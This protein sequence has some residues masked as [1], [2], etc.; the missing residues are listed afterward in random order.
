MLSYFNVAEMAI[1]IVYFE[2]KAD[3]NSLFFPLSS[4][5]YG[6]AGLFWVQTIDSSSL[7]IPDTA[8]PSRR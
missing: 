6:A 2:F 8:L 3:L 5:P 1:K 4:S 7:V